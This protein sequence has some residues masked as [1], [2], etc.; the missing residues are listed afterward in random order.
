MGGGGPEEWKAF[1]EDT[2]F[3]GRA[4]DILRVETEAA[5]LPSWLNLE[6]EE[7]RAAH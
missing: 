7:G 3:S 1:R 6:A 5:D 4:A 2:S